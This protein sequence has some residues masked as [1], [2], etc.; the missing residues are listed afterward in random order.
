V[1]QLCSAAGKTVNCNLNL[2]RSAS[3]TFTVT[4][5]ACELGGN[6][7]AITLPIPEKTV[8][9]NGCSAPVN[10]PIVIM[11]AAGAPRVYPAGAIEIRFTQGVADAGDPVPG[12]PGITLEG[13]FPDWTLN[14]DDGGVPSAPGEPDFDDIVVTLH[15]TAN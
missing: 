11:D 13:S 12:T 2:S 3:L 7:L 9:F 14:I 8:F 6:K 15:A 1:S 5:R 10:Q 4:S